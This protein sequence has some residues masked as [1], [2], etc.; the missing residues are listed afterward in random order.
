MLLVRPFH[1]LPVKAKCEPAPQFTDIPGIL[2]LYGDDAR[3][4]VKP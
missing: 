4:E 1:D 2:D 3:L